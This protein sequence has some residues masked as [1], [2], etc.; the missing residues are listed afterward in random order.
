M[1][2]V[3][4]YG[5]FDPAWRA[6]HLEREIVDSISNQIELEHPD[7]NC[8]V[9]VPSWHEPSVLVDDIINLKPDL[10]V[11]CSLSDPLGPIE[12]MLAVI[13]GRV[14]KFGYVDQGI[15][16][17]FWALACLKYFRHYQNDQVVPAQLEKLYL[18]YNRKPHKHRTELV[19]LLEENNLIDYGIVTLGNSHYTINDN[20]ED[21]I[22]YGGNDVV[23]DV[24]IPN[25]IYS[26]GKLDI[27]NKCLINIVSE[28]QFE[29]SRNTFVSEK[30][31]K[32]IIGLRPFVVNGS[33]SIYTWL[34]NAGFDCFDDLFPVQQ[35]E[36]EIDND[37]EFSNHHL[38]C[39]CLKKYK[40]QNLLEIY[41]KIKPRLLYNQNLFYEY[42]RNQSITEHFTIN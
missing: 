14:I 25:D 39:D 3:K 15:K 7:W 8:V 29:S 42:A 36:Q 22:D 24:G 5:G 32:P 10:T 27:W 19:S 33:P 13:P 9:A 38:I 28:T 31:Y 16:F 6:G 4:L 26:L 21:Y 30:I 11:V 2:I 1:P 37:Y 35:L 18:N 17:D 12:N 41:N 40:N 20:I 23:G 34:K